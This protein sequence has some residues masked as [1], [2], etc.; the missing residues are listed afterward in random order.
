MSKKREASRAA[1]SG[2]R[3][4]GEVERGERGRGEEGV[5]ERKCTQ[6]RPQT[7]PSSALRSWVLF[8]SALHLGPAM[9]ST[10]SLLPPPTPPPP[11]P[12]PTHPAFIPPAMRSPAQITMRRGW[13]TLAASLHELGRAVE[14]RIWPWMHPLRQLGGPPSRNERSGAL[15]LDGIARGG[16]GIPCGGTSKCHCCV[17]ALFESTK[18]AGTEHTP[19]TAVLKSARFSTS[20]PTPPPSRLPAQLLLPT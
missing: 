19:N 4:V 12:L 17:L 10:P 1:Q 14:Q 13:S 3:K 11:P 15:W 16:R 2:D 5:E 7:V 20:T 8:A 6:A 18:Q 9:S